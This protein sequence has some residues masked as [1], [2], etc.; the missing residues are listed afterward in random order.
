VPSGKEDTGLIIC[1]LFTSI[2]ANRGAG[3]KQLWNQKWL[4]GT[5]HSAGL[6]AKLETVVIEEDG[7]GREVGMPFCREL[8][9]QASRR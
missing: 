4:L 7:D 8:E 3:K 5:S 9:E 2:P 1:P 6:F